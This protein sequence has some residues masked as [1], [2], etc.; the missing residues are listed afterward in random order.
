MMNIVTWEKLSTFEQIELSR[1]MHIL[2]NFGIVGLKS[3][4]IVRNYQLAICNNFDKP[5]L[6]I[7]VTQTNESEELYKKF[8]DLYFKK[9]KTSK[10]IQAILNLDDETTEKYKMQCDGF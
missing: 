5:K 7:Q 2:L 9:G 10:E 1:K 8:D 6:Y 4:N 3:N